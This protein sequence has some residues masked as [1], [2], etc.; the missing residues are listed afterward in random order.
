MAEALLEP[1]QRRFADLIGAATESGLELKV[2]A[3]VSLGGEDVARP[4]AGTAQSHKTTQSVTEIGAGGAGD[5]QGAHLTWRGDSAKPGVGAARR[6]LRSD[7]DTRKMRHMRF[8][9]EGRCGHA[10]S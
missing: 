2:T 9:P 1:E 8:A 4:A 7:R 3:G 6:D 5:L 10:H